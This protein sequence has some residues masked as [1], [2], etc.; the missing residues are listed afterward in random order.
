M[1][2]PGGL[3]PEFNFAAVHT[4]SPDSAILHQDNTDVRHAATKPGMCMSAHNKDIHQITSDKSNH[5]SISG[6]FSFRG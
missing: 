5:V 2:S 4:C 6:M 3:S 1:D